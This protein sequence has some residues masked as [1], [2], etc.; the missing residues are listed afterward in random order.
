MLTDFDVA[1]YLKTLPNLKTPQARATALVGQ[2][3]EVLMSKQKLLDGFAVGQNYNRGGM[4]GPGTAPP[5]PTVVS[6]NDLQAMLREQ[7]ARKTRR[8]P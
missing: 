4:P 2:L 8:T 1:N 3:R 7:Q 6:G 5:P